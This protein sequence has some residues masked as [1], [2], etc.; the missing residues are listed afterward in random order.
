M[1]G[2]RNVRIDR[3]YVVAHDES[4]FEIWPPD[5]PVFWG[6]ADMPHLA[7]IELSSGL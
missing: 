2:S 4:R 1:K 6:E 7:F 3:D 5:P